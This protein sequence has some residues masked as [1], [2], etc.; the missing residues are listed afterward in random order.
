MAYDNPFDGTPANPFLASSALAENAV[1]RCDEPLWG[2][3]IRANGD[4]TTGGSDT[5]HWYIGD[6]NT[7]PT[8]STYS[9]AGSA[10][11]LN[12]KT[13]ANYEHFVDPANPTQGLA[14]DYTDVVTVDS[15][16]YWYQDVDPATGLTDF[17]PF[18][19]HDPDGDPAIP[20]YRYDDIS[21]NVEL[22]QISQNGGQT[23]STAD[24]PG[25]TVKTP[26]TG[27]ATHDY[28]FSQGYY[29]TAILLANYNGNIYVGGSSGVWTTAFDTGTGLYDNAWSDLTND[30]KGNGPGQNVHA[31]SL[32]TALDG[33]V[34]LLTATDG[35][36]WEYTNLNLNAAQ[37]NGT[38]SPGSTSAW[39]DLN[40]V[41]FSLGLGYHSGLNIALLTSLAAVPGDPYLNYI[42]SQAAGVALTDSTA[43]GASGQGAA[44]LDDNSRGSPYLSPFFPQDDAIN[45][46]NFP[47]GATVSV[48][49]NNPNIVYAWLDT[50]MV[51]PTTTPGVFL[52]ETADSNVPTENPTL[53]DGVHEI[54]NISVLRK[55]TDGGKTWQTV[56][57][58]TPQGTASEW[59]YA[60]VAY[61]N[62]TSIGLTEN[63]TLVIDPINSSRILVGG[64][65]KTPTTQAARGKLLDEEAPFSHGSF[66]FTLLE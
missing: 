57:M 12:S 9:T 21:G 24:I 64:N 8:H 10:E 25:S 22:V 1:Y 58:S 32:W 41:P 27:S 48:D 40:D 35:G 6:G 46:G 18:G 61:E 42:T 59:D 29:S 14:L 36:I 52:Y 54:F 4:G 17:P 51:T 31:F 37:T 26:P 50:S 7:Y 30:T 53:L 56:T 49:P 39:V 13:S 23:W 34:N 60:H 65:G 5:P 44:M 62:T 47:Y 66:P 45:E 63:P 19:P 33:S 20:A 43:G 28:L 15:N 38:G 2:P 55:S 16:P 3:G 11:Y